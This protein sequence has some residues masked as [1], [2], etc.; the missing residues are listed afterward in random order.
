[1]LQM[2]FFFYMEKEQQKEQKNRTGKP[3]TNVE[4]LAV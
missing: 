2:P 3:V 4:K 1:M